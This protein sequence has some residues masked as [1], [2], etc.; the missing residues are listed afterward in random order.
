MPSLKKATAGDGLF[1]PNL[2]AN[3]WAQVLE[4]CSHLT[5]AKAESQG[6]QRERSGSVPGSVAWLLGPVPQAS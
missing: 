4:V 1:P 3:V 6:S 2:V 5:H